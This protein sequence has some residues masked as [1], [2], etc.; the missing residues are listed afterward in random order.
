LQMC[1]FVRWHFSFFFSVFMQQKF[2]CH[3]VF[4]FVF[5]NER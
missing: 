5:Y 4:G 3:S 2:H 1:C